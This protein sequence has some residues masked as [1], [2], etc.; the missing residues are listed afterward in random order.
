MTLVCPAE[1][2]HAPSATPVTPAAAVIRGNAA[3]LQHLA[4]LGAALAGAR[5]LFLDAREACRRVRPPPA[6]D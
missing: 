6:D 2:D 5:E 4:A 1:L 3:G